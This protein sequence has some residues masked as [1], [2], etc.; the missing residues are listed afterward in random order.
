ME[1]LKNLLIIKAQT[2]MFSATRDTGES[3]KEG[4]KTEKTLQT[5]INPEFL[6]P[7]HRLKAEL[8]RGMLEIS[9]RLDSLEVWTTPVEHAQESIDWLKGFSDRWNVQ[10]DDAVSRYK[11]VQ[12]EWLIAN[13]DR[14]TE[15]LKFS[16]SEQEVRDSLTF[17]YAAYRLPEEMTY[18]GLESSVNNLPKQVAA[19]IANDVSSSAGKG[20]NFSYRIAGTLLRA[21]KKAQMFGF[22]HPEIAA[23]PAEIDAIMPFVPAKG[24]VMDPNAALVIGKLIGRLSNENWIDGAVKKAVEEEAHEPGDDDV[25]MPAFMLNQSTQMD[26]VIPGEWDF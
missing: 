21:R 3:R 5:F 16:M 19:E 8:R 23:L 4:S 9:T 17:V 11:T 1:V 13:P 25:E 22:L 18:G 15:I 2:H 6:K 14:E 12:Q 7:F 26:A 20:I 10:V 24:A